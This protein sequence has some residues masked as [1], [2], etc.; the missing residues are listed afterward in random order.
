MVEAS[1]GQSK[2]A[3]ITKDTKIAEVLKLKPQT[4]GIFFAYGMPCLGCTIALN[5]SVEAAAAIHGIDL[6]ELLSKLNEA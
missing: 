6:E 5:E 3:K 2:E 1:G 4:A